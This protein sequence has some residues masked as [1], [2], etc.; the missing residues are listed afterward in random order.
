M[1]VNESD[2]RYGVE[3]RN[4]DLRRRIE[5]RLITGMSKVRPKSSSFS[6]KRRRLLDCSMTT[7]KPAC[8]RLAADI[9]PS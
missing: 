5:P 2:S 3:S 1:R 8:D 6:H 7:W 4:L 9:S